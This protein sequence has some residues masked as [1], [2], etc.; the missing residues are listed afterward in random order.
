[1]TANAFFA[2][3]LLAGAISDLLTRRIPNWMTG[4]LV[5]AFLPVAVFSGLSWADFGWHLLAGLVALAGGF[6]LH[7]FRLLG[8]GDVKLFAGAAFWLGW[9]ALLPL[10]VVTALAGGLLA[11]IILVLQWFRRD[12]RFLFLHP[13]IGTGPIK[14]GMPYGVAIAMAGIILSCNSLTLI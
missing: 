2:A 10:L 4:F 13:W 11:A 9:S 1:M 5:L 6:G 7:C 8:G 14:S 12:A 3:I